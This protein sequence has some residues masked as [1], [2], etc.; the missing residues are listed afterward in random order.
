MSNFIQQEQHRSNNSKI[1]G[2]AK[3]FVDGNLL[4]NHL[5]NRKSIWSEETSKIMKMIDCNEIS[6]YITQRD[7]QSIWHLKNEL[8]GEESADLIVDKIASKFNICEINSDLIKDALDSCFYDDFDSALMSVCSNKEEV[9]TFITARSSNALLDTLSTQNPGLKTKTPA[10]FLKSYPSPYLVAE[11][12]LQKPKMTLNIG[13]LNIVG[14]KV[15][16]S[17]NEKSKCVVEFLHLISGKRFTKSV[18]GVGAIGI[19]FQAIEETISSETD[20]IPYILHSLNLEN[21]DKGNEA[22][23]HAKVVLS[24]AGKFFT[25]ESKS[26]DSVEAA[27]CAYIEAASKIVRYSTCNIYRSDINQPMWKSILTVLPGLPIYMILLLFKLLIRKLIKSHRKYKMFDLN[28]AGL[29]NIIAQISFFFSI[30]KSFERAILQA[31]R[32]IAL[33]FPQAEALIQISEWMRKKGLDDF[34]LEIGR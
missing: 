29:R 16:C 13:D 21:Y 27:F 5:F 32:A 7:V 4:V 28:L 22:F 14:I 26:R 1:C 10:D 3:V 15:E 34:Q 30:T 17:V 24:G 6:G 33:R 11:E 25:G 19:L 2:K 18:I 9:N 20:L 12:E 8:S 23:T 31:I